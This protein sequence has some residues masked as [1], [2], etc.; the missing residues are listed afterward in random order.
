MSGPLEGFR[1][2]DVSERSPAAAI[3]GMVLSDFGAEVVKVE[4]EGGDPLRGLEGSQVWL[5]GQKSVVVVDE[6]VADGSWGKLRRSADAL[7]DTAQPW[8]EKP[9]GAARRAGPTLASPMHPDGPTQLGSGGQEPAALGSPARLRGAGRG[10][11][12]G[13]C[14]FRRATGRGPSSSAGPTRPTEQRG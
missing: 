13:S 4:P 12:W 5:R 9:G 11:V 6:Q 1:I 7:I 3:A 8:T 2:I 14:I 10:P